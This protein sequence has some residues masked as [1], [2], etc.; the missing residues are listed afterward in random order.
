MV[1]YLMLLRGKKKKTTEE[2]F[3]SFYIILPLD[4]VALAA[5]RKSD[6]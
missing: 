4:N 1:L 2:T 3:L 5:L 6:I